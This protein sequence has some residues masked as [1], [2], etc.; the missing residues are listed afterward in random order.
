M[1]AVLKRVKPKKKEENKLKI[2]YN[3]LKKK[4]GSI[5]EQE[6]L[7]KYRILSEAAKIGRK[8]YGGYFSIARLAIDFDIPV[9]TAKRVLSLEK[10]SKYAWNMIESKKI[11]AHKVA[12]ILMSIK[13][14]KQ[15][16]IIKLA[17]KDNLSTYQIKKI[18]LYKDDVKKLRLEAA[19]SKGFAR[20]WNEINAFIAS[21]TRLDSFL[22]LNTS[23]YP[24]EKKAEV[25]VKLTNLKNKIEEYLKNN[26]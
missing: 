10:A 2:R 1:E 9:S 15:D 12:Q 25:Q 22:K 11:G 20:R 5:E 19:I 6:T 3:D 4:L 8:I 24:A 18:R 23:E 14:E 21:I 13:K 26:I 7:A 17:I 16:E